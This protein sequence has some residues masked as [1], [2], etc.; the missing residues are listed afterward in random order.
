[1][2]CIKLIGFDKSACRVTTD[3]KVKQL[4]SS[5]GH[6][7]WV[8]CVGLAFSLVQSQQNQVVVHSTHQRSHPK[9]T[10]ILTF[11]AMRCRSKTVS[12]AFTRTN[13]TYVLRATS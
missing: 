1:M 12:G 4:P 6:D 9:L 13:A 8:P 3:P 11:G 10:C 5:G 7:S 2:K